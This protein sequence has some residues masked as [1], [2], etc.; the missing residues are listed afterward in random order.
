VNTRQRWTLVAT[1]IGSGIVFLDGTIVN[2]ALPR[3]GAELPASLIGTL[4]G[5]TYIVS[6]YLAV[7][8]ALLI[9]AGALSDHFGR[10]R[11][12]TL[13]LASFG[14]TS[15]LCGIAP[16]LELMVLFRLLQ[17]AAGALLVPGSL[18]IITQTFDGPARAR[19]FGIW[20]SATSALVV[21]GPIT[22]GV[23]VDTVGWR[24]AFLVNV[25]LIALALWA[26]FRYVEESRAEGTSGKFDWLGSLVA[27]LAVG[28]LA[29][30]VIRGEEKAWADPIAWVSLAVGAVALVAFPILMARRP[31]PLV[32]LGL[33]RS[34]AFATINLAT[35]FIYGAL[36]ITQSYQGLLFQG[37][38]GYT[39]T[40]AGAVG[41][42]TGIMLTLL[43][44]R[45]GTLAGRLGARPFLVAGPW[46]MA[47]GLVWLARI[48]AASGAWEAAVGDPASLVPPP[49]VL[50]D[51]LPAMLLF[52]LG[53]SLVVA[54]LT[55][56]LMNSIPTERSGLG[57]AINNA[58]SRVGAPLIGAVIFIAISAT[59]YSMLGSLTGLDTTRAEIRRSFAPLNP[60]KGD[61]TPAELDAA[62]RASVD[63]FHQAMLVSAGLL[64]VGGAVS[65]VGLRGTKAGD[66]PVPEPASE[67]VAG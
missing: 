59:F 50:V 52:G 17:G 11:I 14:V 53:I 20:A 45:I 15:V 67:P 29:F 35:F 9:L 49:D 25:P 51:V 63:A 47:A 6:G 24:I 55:S 44:T 8:A 27:T 40:A 21:L 64:A 22:G 66:E 34:R 7:L 12:F 46:L 10:R 28:G 4:E 56:T 37:V 58:I 16:T 18:A 38:L 42:P 60:P 57:S 2:V 26:T 1:I 32:P 65:L 3:M 61:P 19:A 48:P 31:H 23:I 43:S 62:R 54:P 41:L 39:A 13:G 30:G 36:Y 5:Q 33:F